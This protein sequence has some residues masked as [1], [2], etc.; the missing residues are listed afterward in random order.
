MQ[1]LSIEELFCIIRTAAVFRIHGVIHGL[2]CRRIRIGL[3]LGLILAR[4]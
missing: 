3:W 1:L 4:L 2:Y